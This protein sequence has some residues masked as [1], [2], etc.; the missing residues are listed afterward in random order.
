MAAQKL[1]RGRL[2]QIIVLMIILITAFV[3][4]TV[5]YQPKV[6]TQVQE[7]TCNLNVGDCVFTINNKQATVTLLSKEPQADAPL[8]LQISNVDIA[9]SATVSGITMNMGI[10]PIE[11]TQQK[12][13]WL[14]K[15]TVPD[16][17]H[18]KMTWVIDI[19][20]DKDIY[21]SQFTVNKQ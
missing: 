8:E 19:K 14:G 5:T 11:F 21:S 12:E 15:F 13:G 10:L 6:P 2:I 9:P 18:D 3:W 16:C 4:R 7:T 17:T 20:M 1:T